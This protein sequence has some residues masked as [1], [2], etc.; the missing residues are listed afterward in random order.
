MKL[1]YTLHGDFLKFF[2]GDSSGVD[3]LLVN[4]H[5]CK[6]AYAIRSEGFGSGSWMYVYEL[7]EETL[8]LI[9]SDNPPFK[10][11]FEMRVWLDE[12]EEWLV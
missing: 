7:S 1:K 9:L 12:H 6:G 8:Q 4:P 2:Q 10:D 11:P 5:P 3:E